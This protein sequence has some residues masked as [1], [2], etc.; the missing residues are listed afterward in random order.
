VSEPVRYELKH[1]LK[2][3]FKGPDGEREET[4]AELSLRRIKGKDLRGLTAD[5]SEPQ[6]A[7]H[8]IGRSSGLTAMQVD[9]LDAEDIAAL[10]EVIEGFMPPGLKTGPTPSGT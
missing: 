10:G 6:Q 2:F 4:T 8:L 3:T 9:E 1:P 5:M 7:L